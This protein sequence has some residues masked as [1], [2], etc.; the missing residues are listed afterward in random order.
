MVR[1]RI[2]VGDGG[3][4]RVT[5][6]QLTAQQRF[7]A[8]ISKPEGEID[9]AIAALA[10]AQT[11]YPQLDYNRYLRRLDQMGAE[12]QARLP[13][14]RYPLKM[15]RAINQYLFSELH[16]EGNHRNYYDPRNS[17]LNDVLD[18]RRG[19]PI[20]LALVY[21]E[22]AKRIDFSMA[23]VGMPGHFLIRPTVEGMT[24]FVDVFHQGEILFEEDCQTLIYTLYGEAAT[25]RPQH[26]EPIGP[27][28]FLA[29]M[30]NNLKGIYLHRQDL[31]RRLGIL[32]L[33]LCLTPDAPVD[34]RDRG[35]IHYQL[36]DL[37]AAKA[38][39]SHYLRIAPDRPDAAAVEKLVS[40]IDRVRGSDPV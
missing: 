17:F 27:R 35:L 2:T 10:I 13:E 23:G 12:L 21:L 4:D 40:Q 37:E 16:F 20:S 15:M 11:E 24:I 33:L 6:Q 14:G 38:D 32:N 29:R 1:D 25:L 28:P 36:G 34:Y 9:L 30:L 5:A 18:Q 19:I 39:F 7:Q 3:M 31:P 22:L 26:L 8:E